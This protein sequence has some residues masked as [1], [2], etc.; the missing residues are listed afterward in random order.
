M[1]AAD[2]ISPAFRARLQSCAPAEPVRAT[3]LVDLAGLALPEKPKGRLTREDRNRRAVQFKRLV[4]D[5]QIESLLG[6]HGARR[7]SDQPSPLGAILVEAPAAEILAIESEPLVRAV[8]DDQT[9]LP[10]DGDTGLSAD[11]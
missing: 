9:L 7:V 8:L 3:L 6:R 10:P 5:P 11:G 1:T 4:G 2:K